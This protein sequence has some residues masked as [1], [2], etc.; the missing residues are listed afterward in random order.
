MSDLTEQQNETETTEQPA[1]DRPT[2]TFSVKAFIGGIAV[3]AA[4]AAVL[5]VCLSVGEKNT[6]HVTAAK[7]ETAETGQ[8]SVIDDEV[9]A[10]AQTIEELLSGLYLDEMDTE[11][12]TEG[13]YK[14]MVEALGDPYTVYYDEEETEA[15]EESIDGRYSGI[16]A[17]LSQTADTLELT[18]I[19][20]FED[21]PAMEAGLQPGDVIVEVD[22][23]EV[24][25]MDT[26]AAVALIKGEEGTQVTLKIYREGETDYLT[27]VLTRR[28][29]DIPTVASSML[30]DGIGYI[31]ISSFD[32]VT[33][34]QFAEAMDSLEEQQME[35]L[36]IDL[37]DNPGGRL[38][39]VLD[40]A[41]QF[42]P[43]GLLVYTEDKNGDRTDYNSES[44]ESEVF[45]KPLAVLVNGNSASASEIFA[46]A[47]KD[48]GVGTVI[49]TTTYGKGVVQQLLD[50]QDGTLLKVTISKYFTPSG[51]D[52]NHKGITPDV[53]IELPEEIWTKPVVTEEDDTQLQKALEVLQGQLEQ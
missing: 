9:L 20:C 42:V 6:S 7:K 47:V 11:A 24:T 18:I 29:I 19:K 10:K 38:D 25:G 44:S 51:S 41:E 45:G 21:T 12:M 31:Q 39:I 17:T 46:G 22:G 43:E 15:L 53:E 27:K 49:G 34:D 3:G 14:G 13:V 32:D 8:E 35:A 52:I 23:T 1:E 28:K 16:G 48:R 40:I 37:R 36:I 4:V 30:E 33:A 2:R 5:A 50:L 26:S